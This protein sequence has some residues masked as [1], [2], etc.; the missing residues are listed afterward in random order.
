[1]M[2]NAGLMSEALLHLRGCNF[3]EAE[4]CYREALEKMESAGSHES[5]QAAQLLAHLTQVMIKQ[6]EFDRA[7]PFCQRALAIHEKVG[8]GASFSMAAAVLTL[9][10]IYRAQGREE[11]ARPLEE[12]ASAIGE[13]ANAEMDKKERLEKEKREKEEAEEAEYTD[14]EYTDDE[15]EAGGE[16]ECVG[17][18]GEQGN[19]MEQPQMEQPQGSLQQEGK[20]SRLQQHMISTREKLTR[21][22]KLDKQLSP[23]KSSRLRSAST[24][25]CSSNDDASRRSSSSTASTAESRF[26][27]MGRVEVTEEV[28]ELRLV[29]SAQERVANLVAGGDGN[30]DK[31]DT[32]R[33]GI[34]Q[35][36]AERRRARNEQQER[37]NEIDQ[38]AVSDLNQE[39]AAL[40]SQAKT[41]FVA[42]VRDLP[43]ADG[44]GG[45]PGGFD[46]GRG[47]TTSQSTENGGLE[48][49]EGGQGDGNGVSDGERGVHARTRDGGDWRI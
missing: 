44:G 2:V 13:R 30:E 4:R 3:A 32:F 24:S 35:R 37:S 48:A 20:V 25:D 21:A 42:A 27:R 43:S 49:F 47:N 18:Q 33:A 9:A 15:E 17:P 8:S 28:G 19:E 39:I 22:I 16:E 41:Q 29:A 36:R 6:S 23:D 26:S 11:D 12:R 38:C 5:E 34:L 1:M 31:S 14:E 10:E 7:E 40:A 45:P 46:G